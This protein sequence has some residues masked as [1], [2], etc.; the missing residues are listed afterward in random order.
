MQ[1]VISRI[2]RPGWTCA[3][4][5]AHD[6]IYTRLLA[7][8]VGTSG[9]VVAFEVHPDNA[10]R[11]RKTLRGLGNR[12]AVENIAVTDG[13]AS[14]VTVHAGRR[15]ASQEWNITGFDLDGHPTLAELEVAA[16]SLDDYFADRPLDFVKVDVEGAEALVLHGMRRLLRERK[17]AIAVEFHTEGGW[18]GRNEL[19][20]AGYR[21]LTPDGEAVATGASA[22]RVYQCVALA[23]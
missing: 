16:T 11:L 12:V 6:G 3:D 23:S 14:S 4:V 20:G 9:H 22:P 8:L 5:G 15:R 13:A 10:R 18:A 19:L 1:A 21:L 17:P 7:E 2:V